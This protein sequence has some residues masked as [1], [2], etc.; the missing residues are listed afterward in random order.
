MTSSPNKQ[1]EFGADAAEALVAKVLA[2]GFEQGCLLPLDAREFVISTDEGMEE[3]ASRWAKVDGSAQQRLLQH[4]REVTPGLPQGK[5]TGVSEGFVILTQQCDLARQPAQ[6]PTFEAV[7]VHSQQ[8]KGAS[9][10]RS[11][12]SWRH[13][14][15]ADVDERTLVA[16]SRCRILFDKRALLTFD[17]IQALPDEKNQRR[18]FAWWAGARYFRRPVPTNLYEAIEAPFREALRDDKDFF[19]LADRFVMFVVDAL[20]PERP[21]LI[22]VFEQEQEREE[23][24]ATMDEIFERVPFDGLAEDDCDVQA[25]TQTSIGQFLG[26]SSYTLDLEGFSGEAS[27]VPPSLET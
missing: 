10:L 9:T 7:R 25:I 23:M 17:A 13:L 1:S 12:R 4:E 14:A 18:R 8:A 11:L 26:A 2:G 22:G 15:I 21:R 24:E 27:T 5:L 20:E 6:E 3:L 19:A 16:D